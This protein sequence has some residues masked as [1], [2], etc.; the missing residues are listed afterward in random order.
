MIVLGV[1]GCMSRLGG[2]LKGNDHADMRKEK[3]AG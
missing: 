3:D 2:K 1:Y